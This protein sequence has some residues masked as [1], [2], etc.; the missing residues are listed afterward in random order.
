M[1]NRYKSTVLIISADNVIANRN[2]ELNTTF[3]A[4]GLSLSPGHHYYFTVTA[5]ND[6][7]LHTTVSSDGFVV[8]LDRPVAGI[9]YN[10][11]RY[12][13]YAVQKYTN[14]FELSWRGFLDHDSGIKAYY[15]AVIEDSDIQ[16]V[17]QAF[18]N[19]KKRTSVTLTNLSL[20][21]GKKYYGAVK[22]IDA[23]RHESDIV[24]SKSKLIDTTAP[25]AYICNSNIV[26]HE[27]QPELPQSETLQFP[28]SFE[29]GGLYSVTGRLE[30]DDQY[31]RIKLM[32]EQRIRTH[33]PFGRSHD[34]DLQFH[35][36]FYS[37]FEGIYNVSLEIS[38]LA[39]FR[40]HVNFSRCEYSLTENLQDAVI[41]TQFSANLFKATIKAIDPES[42]IRQ[43][44]WTEYT[45]TLSELGKT[46]SRR[47]FELFFF[48]SWL[49]QMKI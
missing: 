46:Y 45:L 18:T 10:T 1:L 19:V 29:K 21:H 30:I 26:L 11:G 3:A 38:S 39:F 7:G 47:Q 13:N 23:A 49:C 5:Y 35:F 22:A 34:G 43:V 17:V 2:V 27:I 48:E 16:T 33:L 36:T 24:S 44:S 12:H 20:K 32:V 28:V 14:S 9:V 41:V 25:S 15:V 42:T 31:P 8:D 40:A 6:A 4:S 37:N